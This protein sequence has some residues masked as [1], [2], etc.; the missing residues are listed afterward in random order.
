MTDSGQQINREVGLT[1][2]AEKLFQSGQAL[3]F[4]F[5]A[6][7]CKAKAKLRY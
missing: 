7:T 4:D 5:Y 3:R 6:I 1:T 2:H